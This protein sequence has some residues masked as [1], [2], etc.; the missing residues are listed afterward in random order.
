V[1]SKNQSQPDSVF[2]VGYRSHNPLPAT[3]AL[4][5]T[6]HSAKTLAAHIAAMMNARLE[7]HLVCI[8]DAMRGKSNLSGRSMA[9]R[10]IT[11]LDAD[12][13]RFTPRKL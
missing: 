9:E 6:D 8:G 1:F 3:I 11:G 4:A 10:R 2:S 5:S 12:D 7:A 13:H